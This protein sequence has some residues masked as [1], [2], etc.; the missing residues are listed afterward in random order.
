MVDA[1]W[2]NGLCLKH[3]IPWPVNAEKM[4]DRVSGKGLFVEPIT[5]DVPDDTQYVHVSFRSVHMF[6]G[7][8]DDPQAHPLST[9]YFEVTKENYTQLQSGK[10]SFEVRALLEGI[11]KG[12]W[13]PYFVLSLLCFG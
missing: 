9:V 8:P 13:T 12:V 11:P 6:L 1:A 7:K 3:V 2:K 5:V 4:E 10:F